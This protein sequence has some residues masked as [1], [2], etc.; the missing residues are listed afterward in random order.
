MTGVGRIKRGG[1][2]LLL[3]HPAQRPVEINV[4]TFEIGGIR[5]SD[6]IGEDAVTLGDPC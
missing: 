2:G 4:G 5:V 3:D 1:F 6:I